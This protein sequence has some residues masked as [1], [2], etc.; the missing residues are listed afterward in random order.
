MCPN[1]F[2]RGW[3]EF[4]VFADEFR[5]C[6]YE[7]RCS[8]W[9][10]MSVGKTCV[11]LCQTCGRCEAGGGRWKAGHVK[12]GNYGLARRPRFVNGNQRGCTVDFI[13]M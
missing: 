9:G 13:A 12:Q 11:F 10:L 1:A 4:R 3:D 8:C 6:V 7:L 2:G 5:V